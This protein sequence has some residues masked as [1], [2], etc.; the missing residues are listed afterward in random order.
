MM[1]TIYMLPRKHD[2]SFMDFR[3]AQAHGGVN[4]AE[5]ERVYTGY[6]DPRENESVQ[7]VLELIFMEHNAPDRP[8]SYYMRSLSVS[9]LVDLEGSGT[10]F[11]DSFGFKRIS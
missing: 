5:Y 2:N 6:I 10:W 9:D 7:D 3:W 1:Y 11:C 4:K 8:N